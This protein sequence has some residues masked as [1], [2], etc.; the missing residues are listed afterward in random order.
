MYESFYKLDKTPFSATPDPDFFFTSAGHREALAALIYGIQYRK[1]FISLIGEVGTGKTTVLR[2]YIHSRYA[3]NLKLIYVFNPKLNYDSFLT[4]VLREFT[5]EIPDAEVEKADLLHRYL[6]AYYEKGINVVIVIDEAQNT[7]AETLESMRML[8]NIETTKHKLVQIVLAGQPELETVLASHSLRQLRQRLALNIRLSALSRQES[9]EYIAH[10]TMRAG[11][12]DRLFSDA[13]LDWI[14]DHGEGIPRKI[15]M[16][17][18]NALIT[19]FGSDQFPIGLDVLKEIEPDLKL[20]GVSRTGKWPQRLSPATFDEM[21]TENLVDNASSD[22]S[23][24]YHESTLDSSTSDIRPAH[25][26]LSAESIEFP[27][28][29]RIE[30]EKAITAVSNQKS[31]SAHGV[32]AADKLAQEGSSSSKDQIK[33]KVLADSTH[34]GTEIDSIDLQSSN[35]SGA[36]GHSKTTPSL[37]VVENEYERVDYGTVRIVPRDSSALKGVSENNSAEQIEKFEK[38]LESQT[39]ADAAGDKD[40]SFETRSNLFNHALVKNDNAGDE[41]TESEHSVNTTPQGGD[42]NATRTEDPSDRDT[43]T[44]AQSDGDSSRNEVEGAVVKKPSTGSVEQKN[45][46]RDGSEDDDFDPVA[47]VRTNRVVKASRPLQ[48]FKKFW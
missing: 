17:C 36:S 16:I 19:G 46:K 48:R 22:A 44:A 13:A 27:D 47:Y 31:P 6:V 38:R 28:E 26:K 20:L 34:G 12:T 18:D 1:G 8:S 7:P 37:D 4:V 41:K 32:N 39:T 23:S 2:S 35:E 25:H 29:T 14:V 40:L 33:Q 42:S 24:E 30:V 11:G 45:A 5:K 43:T 10:R 21:V 9:L 3:K 15:N